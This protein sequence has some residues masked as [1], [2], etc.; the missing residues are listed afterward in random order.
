MTDRWNEVEPILDAALARE[1]PERAAFV[2]QACAGDDALR[3]EVESLLAQ[4]AVA[5]GLLSTPGFVLEVESLE[6][7][8]I[9][10]RTIG[11][12]TI[13][14]L[15]GA[16]GMGE[17]YRAHDMQLD[18]DVAIKILPAAFTTDSD[19]LARFAKE[20]KTL[21]A[22]NHPQIAAIYGIQYVEG[23]PAL[24]LELVEGATVAERLIEG[25][26]PL[27]TAI[28]V[29][30]QIAQALEAAHGR[31]IIHRDLKPANI[32]ITQTGSVKLLDFGLAKGLQQREPREALGTADPP[33]TTSS[34]G[35][36]LG[37]AAYMSPEQATGQVVDSRSDLF[38]FGAVLY[39]ILTGRPA[40]TGDTVQQVLTAILTQQPPSPRTI[41]RAIPPAL[42]RMVMRL[43]AKDREAR[44]QTAH[45][46][47]VELQRVG[48][49][50]ESGAHG[51]RRWIE[52]GVAAIVLIALG[53]IGWMSWRDTPVAPVVQRQY[54]Q[55]TYF[56]DSATSPALSSDGRQLTFIRGASTFQSRG[57]I[58]IK[59]LPD[60]EPVPVTSDDR[61]KAYPVFSPDGS[62]IAYTVTM[63]GFNW[64]TWV[65]NLNDRAPRLWL[66]NASGLGWLGAGR[67]V[68]SEIIKGLHMAVVT[69]DEQRHDVRSVYVPSSKEG[70]AH[71]SS[72]SPDGAWL[73]ITEMDAPVW[74][75]CRLVPID[76]SASGRRVG[77]AGQC[78]SAAWSPDGKWMYFSS[79]S[80]GSSHIWRQQFPDGAPEQITHG[81]SEEEGLALD[82][83]GR[84]LLT[85]AGTRQSSVWIHDERGEREISREGYAFIPTTPNSGTSRPLSTVGRSVYYLVRQGA[86][87][88]TG[89]GERVGELW[90]TDVARG[91]SRPL[92]AGR[93]VIS[94]DISYDG[95]QLAF[96]ALDD[97][98]ISRV[99]LMRL[100]RPDEPRQLSALE[101]DSPRFTRAGDIFCRGREQ[102]Q[103]FV[104][105][106]QPGGA[107]ERALNQ[108][109]LFFLTVSPGGDWVIAKVEDDPGR[110]SREINKAF[111]TSGAGTPVTLC[112]ACEI[113]WTPD[114]RSLI[115]RFFPGDGPPRE[116][117]IMPLAPGT[118]LPSFP[119]KG[120]R[121]KAD[122]AG[123]VAR[124]INGWV[125]PSSTGSAYVFART[126]T[127]RNIY[128]IALR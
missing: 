30:L 104:Y 67:L 26:L 56:T 75:P 18:R 64:D 120:F 107:T 42:D 127:Q 118:S 20:A 33:T 45:D 101:M 34:P 6:A 1:P 51:T 77:P 60:G 81:P 112:Y 46:V 52:R 54:T 124:E 90:V 105:R 97:R 85:S 13:Q 82:P 53:A 62:R 21:A 100:D 63:N 44:H 37:T 84:S 5:N 50:L 59:E 87:R 125:Y 4:E 29:S 78:T 99:W 16:G 38:S 35:V 58:Y 28:D 61:L 47:R 103:T 117:L 96:A 8:A 126:S 27:R 121:S 14:A 9:V 108:P 25:A 80:S 39:E 102:G 116:T 2:A 73:L 19:R 76:G 111:P 74:Q 70:M 43:L 23:V 22:L 123:L 10:G 69:A 115:V 31:E 89:V 93:N 15:I 7:Q 113:D 91:A 12:Y 88:F 36:L 68:F 86:V 92:V 119:A 32:K 17:V 55:I 95:T 41:N 65:V 79:N 57:Q 24:V 49:D 48:R 110:V 40:F 11:P 71:R 114:G 106:L 83:D 122:L 72:V 109:V 128:R 3:R 98:G 66:K 94:Y